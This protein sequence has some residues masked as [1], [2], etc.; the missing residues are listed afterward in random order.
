MTGDCC[1]AWLGQGRGS[2][3]KNNLTVID[4]RCCGK[5]RTSEVLFSL[6]S[7]KVQGGWMHIDLILLLCFLCNEGRIRSQSKVHVVYEA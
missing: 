5:L 7:G 6:A 2:G 4:S 1:D 3:L